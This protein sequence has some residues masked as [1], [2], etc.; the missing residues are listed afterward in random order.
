MQPTPQAVASPILGPFLAWQRE[1]SKITLPV[2]DYLDII[3]FLRDTPFSS[4]EHEERCR[5]VGCGGRITYRILDSRKKG[6]KEF[7]FGYLL[8]LHC[9][10]PE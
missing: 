6:M 10:F 7:H 4:P 8:E 1:D 3:T 2:N 9:V 5:L